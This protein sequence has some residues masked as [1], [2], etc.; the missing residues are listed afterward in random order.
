MN[1]II[2]SKKFYPITRTNLVNQQRLIAEFEQQWNQSEESIRKD[3]GRSYHD[4]FVRT[5]T[6]AMDSARTEIEQV[7][8]TIER[9]V[10]TTQVEYSYTVARYSERIRIWFWQ[11]IAPTIV[12]DFL[13]RKFLT[14]CNGQP[15]LLKEN[16]MLN[17]LRNVDNKSK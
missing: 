1:V 4:G 9:A 3:Y 11:T 16:Q 10:T 2:K 6:L 13:M 15:K 12:V 17:P 5:M 14:D 7:V 8:G